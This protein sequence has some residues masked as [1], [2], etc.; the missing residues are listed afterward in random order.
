M[1]SKEA[2]LA[3]D[4]LPGKGDAVGSIESDELQVPVP[5]HTTEAALMRRIDLRVV[6]FLSLLYLVA[7]LDRINISNA[8][9]FGLSSDLKLTGVQY[10][11]CLTIFFVPYIFFE[12]PSNLLLKRFSPRVWLSICGMGFSACT[13]FQG[14]VHNYGGLLAC[15]FFM[16]VF[17]C[18]MFPGCFYLL[19]MWYRRAD[20]QRRYSFF[21][22]STSLA[23]AFGGLLASAIGKSKSVP[24]G[25]SSLQ[26][27]DTPIVDHLHGHRGWRYIFW[28][29]GAVG[30]M[31]CFAFLFTFP[32]L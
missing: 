4:D 13:V 19:G 16:G 23:G 9:S 18:G 2:V 32:S 1:P 10:N 17:E 3:S 29:E 12:I 5:S 8:R 21:F 22:S 14:L 27:A 24:L 6:P 30:F 15:R 28:L 7:F 31:I 26:L 11:T 20:A 25:P